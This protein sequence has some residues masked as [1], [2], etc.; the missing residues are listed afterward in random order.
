MSLK[1]PRS[2]LNGLQRNQESNIVKLAQVVNS[3]I[4]TE[5]CPVTWKTVIDAIEGPLINNKQ[6]AN[7]IRKHLADPE[8]KCQPEIEQTI[9]RKKTMEVESITKNQGIYMLFHYDEIIVF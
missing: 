3:W 1:V 2:V 7:T 4:T 8:L 9:C 6:V 5:S